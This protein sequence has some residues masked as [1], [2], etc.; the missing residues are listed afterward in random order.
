MVFS[1]RV[2][3][4]SFKQFMINWWPLLV[5][6]MGLVLVLLA[7]GTKHN[8]EASRSRNSTPWQ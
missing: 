4:F 1:F 7:L 2:V 6:L 5:V 3:P 8:G